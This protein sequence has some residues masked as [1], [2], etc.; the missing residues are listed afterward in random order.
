[1]RKH[2]VKSTFGRTGHSWRDIRISLVAVGFLF[3][4][5]QELYVIE[6]RWFY[7]LQT[8]KY[9]LVVGHVLCFTGNTRREVQ[10]QSKLDQPCCK[11]G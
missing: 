7:K 10:T 4:P 3:M 1:M 2:D 9:I 5:V 11:N 8:N 6:F